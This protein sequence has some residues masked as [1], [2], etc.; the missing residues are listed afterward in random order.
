MLRRILAVVA[1]LAVAVVLVVLIQKLGHSLYPPPED[2]SQQDQEFI[3]NYV[4]SL[5]WGPLA[6]VAASYALATLGGGWVAAAIAGENSMIYSGFV[7]L[8]VLGGAISAM[9]AIP[10]PTWFAAT[11]VIGIAAGA[12][13]GAS[14]ASHGGFNSRAV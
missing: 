7:A 3:T 11:T 12:L 2:L 1:G 9:I 5:P 4:A 8:C 10:H 6:F 13:V 14:L